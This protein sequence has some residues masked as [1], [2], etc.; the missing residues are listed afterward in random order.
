[1]EGVLDHHLRHIMTQ[2]GGVDICVT[3][4]ARVSD[5]PLPQRVFRR[6]SPE[7][8]HDCKTASGVPV[9]VQLLGSHPLSM[10]ISACRAVTAGAQ[11]IDL[12]FGCPAKTVNKNKGG[13]IL[14]REPELVADIVCAVRDAVPDRIPVTAKM[15]LGFEDRLQYR[16]NAIAITE[17]GAAE[18]CVHARSRTDG[19]KPPAYWDVIAEIREMVDVPVIANGEIWSVDDWKNCQQQSHCDDFMIGRGWLATPDLGL[20]IK[21]AAAGVPYTPMAWQTI[22]E[23]LFRY[24]MDTYIAYGDKNRGNRV[25]QWLYYLK[26]TYPEAGDFFATIKRMKEHTDFVSA[27][28]DELGVKIQR[29]KPSAPN[30]PIENVSNALEHHYGAQTKSRTNKQRRDSK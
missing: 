11:T 18:L 13:S 26:K 14:L 9:R 30:A 5:I 25:K 28:N 23:H 3:E 19:Y 17:S 1:M 8:N 22:R 20:Q 21:A 12:N 29:L 16:E 6:L 24:Y 15:R 27:F 4:F 7:I 2:I 10:A